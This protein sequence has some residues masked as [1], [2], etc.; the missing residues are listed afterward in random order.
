MTTI[1]FT[2]IF[3]P[4]LVRL[5]V[6]EEFPL[7]ALVDTDLWRRVF[8]ETAQVGEPQQA[9]DPQF[10]WYEVRIAC[11]P[12]QDQTLL[13]TY[14][15]PEPAQKGEPKF[16]AIRLN[17]QTRDARRAVLYTLRKPASIFDQWDIHY[18]PLPNQQNRTEQKFR[19]K[20]EGTDSLRNFVLSVQH[21]DFLDNEYEH[22][23]LSRLKSFFGS[24]LTPQQ[25]RSQAAPERILTSP[26]SV[27]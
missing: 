6:N 7:H 24:A 23:W 4:H 21:I 15:L 3:L 12:L 18:L 16:V 14:T 25:D 10:H 8:P 22:T 1:E 26:I 19:C 13:L 11:H 17:T 2:D 9:A 27:Q 5:Y 20:I